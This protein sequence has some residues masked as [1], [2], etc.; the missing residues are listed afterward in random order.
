M[1]CYGCGQTDE[2]HRAR[3]L[4]VSGDPRLPP[5]MYDPLSLQNALQIKRPA[6]RDD[7]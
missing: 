3:F 4:E 1:G 7:F 5:R 6:Q 2:I